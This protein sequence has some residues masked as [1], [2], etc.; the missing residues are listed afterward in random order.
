MHENK[1]AAKIKGIKVVENKSII[2]I[3]NRC[4]PPQIVLE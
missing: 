1:R 3:V 4:T 2:Y